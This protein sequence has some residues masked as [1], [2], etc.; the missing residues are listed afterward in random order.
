[1]SV[2]DI[3]IASEGSH[4]HHLEPALQSR[5]EVGSEQRLGQR[6][7]G[8]LAEIQSVRPSGRTDGIGKVLVPAP[9]RREWR[10]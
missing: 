1:M 10:D 2:T 9:P 7:V 6:S 8:L 5:S 3:R 4:C